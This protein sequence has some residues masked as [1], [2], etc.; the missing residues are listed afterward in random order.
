MYRYQAKNRSRK[1][2][3]TTGHSVYL[4]ETWALPAR[5]ESAALHLRLLKDIFARP[6][7]DENF[8]TLL[9]PA[10]AVDPVANSRLLSVEVRIQATIQSPPRLSCR[11]TYLE[12]W[13]AVGLVLG[14]GLSAVK[15]CAIFASGIC[16]AAR[17]SC[18]SASRKK[19][20][21]SASFL[22]IRFWL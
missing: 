19:A 8:V 15:N 18:I 10:T 11:P 1:Q 22:F 4:R 12:G 21:K 6:F 17:G 3:A 2:T 16:R 13:H 9:H 7:S 14:L 20:T 5:T